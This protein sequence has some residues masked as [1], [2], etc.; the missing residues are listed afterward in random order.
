M[1]TPLCIVW[2]SLSTLLMGC[3]SNSDVVTDVPNSQSSE[4][5]TSIAESG[6]VD[7]IR[8]AHN[9]LRETYGLEPLSWDGHLAAIADQWAEHLAL[10]NGCQMEHRPGEEVSY[11]RNGRNFTAYGT[12]VDGRFIGE[13]LYWQAT[14]QV[15]APLAD[16][17]AVVEA[18]ASEVSDYDYESNTC[19]EGKMCGHYTQVIWSNT[20]HVGCA[21]RTCDD[22]GS[23]V[24]VCNYFPAGNYVGEWPY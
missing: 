11:V 2:L 14:T 4:G 12:Y 3:G 9:T 19:A 13:N 23:Q 21:Y 20:T 17:N 15:P 5:M 22:S 6:A 16:P 18:W 10:E 7:G 8:A 1:K 24:W